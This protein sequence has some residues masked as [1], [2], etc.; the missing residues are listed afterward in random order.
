MERFPYPFFA[1][2]D[3]HTYPLGLV[4]EKDSPSIRVLSVDPPI[5]PKDQVRMGE[6]F[7]LPHCPLQL[8]PNGTFSFTET[9]QGL[10]ASFQVKKSLSPRLQ[11]VALDVM[12]AFFEGR[13]SD[14]LQACAFPWWKD[15][16]SFRVFLTNVLAICAEE[17]IQVGRRDRVRRQMPFVMTVA[18]EAFEMISPTL[19]DES[20][21]CLFTLL[22]L[23]WKE[24]R[25]VP[26]PG[27]WGCTLGVL[28]H[29]NLY[30]EPAA[31]ELMYRVD[32]EFRRDVGR[33]AWASLQP[34][35]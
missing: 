30:A 10:Q 7:S 28:P 23:T 21:T 9:G 20:T 29:Q 11:H 17:E 16:E 2:I 13:R 27:E 6:F 24:H 33:R 8:L 31:A 19:R 25:L 34:S 26:L 32:D 12:R 35:N 3:P 1:K 18:R 4:L 15:D 5:A 22:P 14:L